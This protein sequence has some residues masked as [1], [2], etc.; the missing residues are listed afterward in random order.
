MIPTLATTARVLVPRTAQPRRMGQRAAAN[1]VAK[2]ANDPGTAAPVAS[3]AA[4]DPTTGAAAA[5][6]ATPAEE[7]AQ[8]LF[9]KT[10]RYDRWVAP[11]R[12]PTASHYGSPT[13]LYLKKGHGRLTLR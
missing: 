12:S 8:V 3:G 6:G 7:P 2:A 5:A 9:H 11:R 13:L 10:W 1:A 4:A